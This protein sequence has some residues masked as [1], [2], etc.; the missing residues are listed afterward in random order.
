[1]MRFVPIL[2][3]AAGAMCLYMAAAY[4]A[5]RGLSLAVGAINIL[6]GCV[7]LV[8]QRQRSSPPAGA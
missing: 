4:E 1:M 3:F 2:F 6:A 5:S 8:H 7:H